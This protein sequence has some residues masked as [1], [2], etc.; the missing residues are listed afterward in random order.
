M[1][2]VTVASR[3]AGFTTDGRQVGVPFNIVSGGVGPYQGVAA[4]DGRGGVIA[5]LKGID[6]CAPGSAEISDYDGQSGALVWNTFID[7]DCT[8]PTVSVGPE[9]NIHVVV[10]RTSLV[11]LDANTGAQLGQWNVPITDVTS[12]GETFFFGGLLSN[13]VVDANGTTFALVNKTFDEANSDDQVWLLSVPTTG[14]AT[15]TII[16]SGGV[17]TDAREAL[18]IPDGQ[19]SAYAAWSDNNN[20]KHISHGAADTIVPIGMPSEMVTDDAGVLYVS[21]NTTSAGTIKALSQMTPLWT[22]Q[23]SEPLHVLGAVFGGAL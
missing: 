13:P 17:W 14:A 8:N 11:T 21:S 22:Y 1:R 10:G 19:G 4:A 3:D 9:G 18:L 7:Y 20:A 5:F 23:G 6:P 12:G 16:S 2:T 15:T